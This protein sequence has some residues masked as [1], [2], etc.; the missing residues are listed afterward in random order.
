MPTLDAPVSVAE[1]Y[2]DRVSDEISKTES[3]LSAGFWQGLSAGLALAWVITLV[4]WWRSRVVKKD[5]I[6]QGSNAAQL[7]QA[8]KSVKQ[9]CHEGEQNKLKQALIIW[10]QQVWPDSPATSLGEIGKRSPADLAE[11]IA[12]LNN[13]LYSQ[14]KNPWDGDSFWQVFKSSHAS[15]ARQQDQDTGDLE[16]LYRL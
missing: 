6:S 3:G 10:G 8:I 13:S 15:S 14:Q 11:K 1:A 5:V 12:Q 9:A 4:F 16:P 7:K 2:N